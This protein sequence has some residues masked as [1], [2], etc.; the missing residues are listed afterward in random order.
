VLHNYGACDEDCFDLTYNAVT[1]F[2]NA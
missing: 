2:Y 1:C